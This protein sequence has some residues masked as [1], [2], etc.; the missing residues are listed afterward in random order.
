MCYKHG[1]LF[2]FLKKKHFDIDLQIV[3]DLE[4]LESADILSSLRFSLYV[5]PAVTH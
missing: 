4:I 1:K 5:R 2:F 3:E